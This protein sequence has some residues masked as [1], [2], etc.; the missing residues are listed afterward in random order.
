MGASGVLLPLRRARKPGPESG[1]TQLRSSPALGHLAA[2]P[3]RNLPSASWT[4]LGIGGSGSFGAIIGEHLRHVADN[5]QAINVEGAGHWVAE[6]RPAVVADTTQVPAACTLSESR[7]CLHYDLPRAPNRER[8]RRSWHE[9]LGG[10]PHKRGKIVLEVAA[11][12]SPK[13]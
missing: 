1:L 5:V 2:K 6:E 11:G 4:V 9:M 3:T 12:S 7:V 10:A 8:F 13:T